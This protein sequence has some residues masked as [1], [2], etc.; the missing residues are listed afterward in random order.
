GLIDALASLATLSAHPRLLADEVFEILLTSGAV[1]GVALLSRTS[2]DYVLVREFGWPD[3]VVSLDQAVATLMSLG[4]V[5]SAEVVLAVKPRPNF[6]ARSYLAGVETLIRMIVSEEEHRRDRLRSASVW[7]TE[8]L[9]GEAS[10]LY[11]GQRMTDVLGQ[12][13]KV[14]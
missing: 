2:G 9:F 1:E 5:E 13:R 8:Y 4:A 10:G 14:A 7:P 11:G 12:A 3:A 6:Q